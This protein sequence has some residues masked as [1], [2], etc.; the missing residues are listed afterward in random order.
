MDNLSC[1]LGS[2][3][4]MMQQQTVASGLNLLFLSLDFP[5]PANNGHRLRNWGLLCALRAEGHQITLLTFAPPG[6]PSQSALDRVSEI[7]SETTIVPLALPK[8][9]AAR[10]LPRA[11]LSV[12]SSVPYSVLRFRSAAM[13]STLSTLLAS[14]R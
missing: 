1:G 4:D 3:T 13:Q 2:K 9:S 8:A 14:R 6:E 11:A 5:F 12:L 10:S 7:C